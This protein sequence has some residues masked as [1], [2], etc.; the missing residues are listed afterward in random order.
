MNEVV[1]SLFNPVQSGQLKS[2]HTTVPYSTALRTDE[3]DVPVVLA[4]SISPL[5]PCSDHASRDL[6]PY[7]AAEGKDAHLHYLQYSNR[8]PPCIFGLHINPSRIWNLAPVLQ[9][10]QR[11]DQALAVSRPKQTSSPAAPL[12]TSRRMQDS[13]LLSMRETI[14]WKVRKPTTNICSLQR[15]GSNKNKKNGRNHQHAQRQTFH[16]RRPIQSPND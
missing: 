3:Q 1:S 13:S 4:L 14:S 7:S 5:P 9:E 6:N 15:K 2:C 8:S 16:A 10:M 11:F 12:A